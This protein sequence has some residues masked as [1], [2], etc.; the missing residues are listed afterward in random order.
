MFDHISIGVR[1]RARST[2]FYDAALKPLGITRLYDGEHGVGYGATRA[3]FWLN[4]STS[5][6]PRNP[7]SGCHICFR[8]DSR[9]AVE[10]VHALAL[11]HGG[12]D[13]GGAGLRPQSAPGHY[14]AF[15]WTPPGYRTA[16]LTSP[17]A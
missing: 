9:A 16:A 10:A 4:S 2:A 3:Q 5:P 12:A 8:T 17:P 15:V 13:D 7:N 6:A 14:A 1:D 11:N